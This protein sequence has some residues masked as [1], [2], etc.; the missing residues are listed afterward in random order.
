[1]T[2]LAKQF[3]LGKSTISSI[4]PE[5][6]QAIWEK[7]RPVYMKLPDEEEWKDVAEGFERTWNFPN[8]CGSID[9][10]HVRIQAPHK[11]GS[12]HFNYKQYFSVVLRAVVDSNGLFITI[13]VGDFGRNSDGGVLSNSKFGRMLADGT[14]ELPPGRAVSD[15]G[16]PLPMVFVADEAYP[17]Q[18]NL[19]RP[20]P[21]KS[22]DRE[23]R[24]F[25][26]RLS[27]ARKVVEMAFGMLTTKWRVFKTKINMKPEGVSFV[28]AAACVL[29]NYIRR[30]ERQ[31]YQAS[32]TQPDMPPA[33]FIPGST[34]FASNSQRP[35]SRALQ[36]RDKFN[37]FFNGPGKLPW[38]DSYLFGDNNN[39][40]V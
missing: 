15:G 9:G 8:C 24:V 2:S 12:Q 1:M 7:L 6:C 22:F 14:L 34:E 19:M 31:M 35:G 13:D 38:Q 32:E 39:Y 20:Y 17:L 40:S 11:S 21:K 3:R 5:C 28:V 23:K 26:Y 29:H 16:E 25:N 30:A 36:V 4:I 10:K 18:E 33:P 27:R 37:A